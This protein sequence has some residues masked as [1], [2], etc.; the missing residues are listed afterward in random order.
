MSNVSWED[1]VNNFIPRLN[2]ITGKTFRLPTEAEWEY[3]ARGGNKSNGYEYSGSNCISEVAWYWEN[4]YSIEVVG[5]KLSNELDIYDMSGNVKE[6]CSDWY[7]YGYYSASPKHNPQGPSRR[8]CDYY[9]EHKDKVCRGGDYLTSSCR[10][11]SR[12]SYPLTHGND[13]IGF[14][15]V[16]SCQ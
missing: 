12:S 15:L 5:G 3:A 1:V 11:A 7:L 6:W 10:V 14:R 13:K 2:K 4:T 9:N 16:C 8:D